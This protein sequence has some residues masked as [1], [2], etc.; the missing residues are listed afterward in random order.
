MALSE[1]GY[2]T[3]PGRVAITAILAARRA[4]VAHLMVIHPIAAD[5]DDVVF[6]AILLSHGGPGGA[7]FGVTRG[8]VSHHGDAA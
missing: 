4:T 7:A 2:H 8:Q 6:P 1:P 3:Q 5:K